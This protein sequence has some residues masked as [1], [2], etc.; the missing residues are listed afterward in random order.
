MLSSDITHKAGIVEIIRGCKYQPV[1]RVVQHDEAK[2]AVS[3]FIRSGRSDI[4]SLQSEVQR[5]RDRM[6]D[7]EF[8]RPDTG[9]QVR[10]DGFEAHLIASL[11]PFRPNVTPGCFGFIKDG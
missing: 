7:S 2:R 11:S 5:L 8:D 3:K 10:R 6:T 1:A 4:S 9:E